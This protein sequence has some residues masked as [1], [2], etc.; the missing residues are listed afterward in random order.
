MTCVTCVTCNDDR[1]QRI[2]NAYYSCHAKVQSVHKIIILMT[3]VVAQTNQEIRY[4]SKKWHEVKSILKRIWVMLN[5]EKFRDCLCCLLAVTECS[6]QTTTVGVRHDMDLIVCM[7]V[8]HISLSLT[9][10]HS[11]KRCTV[12]FM[13]SCYCSH[14]CS[15]YILYPP[16][17]KSQR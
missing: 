7:A 14:Y 3:H 2:P 9:A 17:K 11:H 16:Y 4:E 15:S 6:P 12:D 1:R 13:L 8:T 10:V 5:C